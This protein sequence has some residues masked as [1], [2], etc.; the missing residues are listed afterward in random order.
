MIN[1]NQMVAHLGNLTGNV[2]NASEQLSQTV[3]EIQQVILTVDKEVSS[4]LSQADQ[5]VVAVNELDAT[6]KKDIDGGLIV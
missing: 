6:V 4:G 1:I 5:V 2:R 3:G